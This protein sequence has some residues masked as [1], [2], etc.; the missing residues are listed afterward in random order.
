[1]IWSFPRKSALLLITRKDRPFG[2]CLF[3]MC[4]MDTAI[5]LPILALT[6][7]CPPMSRGQRRACAVPADGPLNR[8]ATNK[9]R[10][11]VMVNGTC[12]PV[13]VVG[14]RRGGRL[15]RTGDGEYE[16]GTRWGNNRQNGWKKRGRW[17][18]A[19]PASPDAGPALNQRLL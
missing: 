1:M 18:N 16:A 8:K 2:S 7:C 10:N 12:R 17:F 13:G 11:V 14:Q 4:G 15:C 9:K 6:G 5:L 3:V 19:G